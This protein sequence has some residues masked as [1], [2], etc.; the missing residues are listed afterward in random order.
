MSHDSCKVIVTVIQAVLLFFQYSV[1]TGLTLGKV[2]SCLDTGEGWQHVGHLTLEKLTQQTIF[3]PGKQGKM[4]V[5]MT[6]ITTTHT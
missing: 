5:K 4:D 6:V 1:E 2:L 3:Q